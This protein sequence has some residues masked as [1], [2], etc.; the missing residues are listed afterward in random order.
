M[1][2]FLFLHTKMLTLSHDLLHFFLCDL[3]LWK[4]AKTKQEALKIRIGKLDPLKAS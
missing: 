1:I 4:T 2:Y 3:V